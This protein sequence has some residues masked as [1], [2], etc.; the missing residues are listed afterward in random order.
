MK[1]VILFAG[2]AAAHSAVRS[3]TIDGNLSASPLKNL[4]VFRA[5]TPLTDI[6]PAML[7][8]TEKLVYGELSGIS[9]MSTTSQP[10]P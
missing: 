9:M 5:L 2:L 7:Y 6:Q 1:T 3:I 10:W 8:W 4:L